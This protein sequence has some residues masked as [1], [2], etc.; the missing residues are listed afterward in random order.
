MGN[1]KECNADDDSGYEREGKLTHTLAH[2][3]LYSFVR[4]Y[5]ASSRL[6]ETL[7]LTLTGNT[8]QQ[9]ASGTAFHSG[10]A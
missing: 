4:T 1:C 9:S 8:D 7:T 6:E 3:V 10:S 2:G 5:D